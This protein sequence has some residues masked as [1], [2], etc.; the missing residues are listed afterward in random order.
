MRS[1]PGP[2]QYTQLFTSLGYRKL[3]GNKPKPHECQV[4]YARK[5]PI[6]PGFVRVSYTRGDIVPAGVA[7]L[8]DAPDSKSGDL[9]WSCGF[10]PHLQHHQLTGID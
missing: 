1:E 9:H 6:R 4:T 2:S 5:S 7:E 3:P 8:A 10:D